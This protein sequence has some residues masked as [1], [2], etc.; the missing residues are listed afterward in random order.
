MKLRYVGHA[1]QIP[2]HRDITK[3]F[4]RAIFAGTGAGKT[5]AGARDAI[6][7]ALDNPG[8]VGY[9]YEPSYMM[10]KRVLIPTL[11]KS[12]LLGKPFQTNPLIESYNQSEFKVTWRNHSVWYFGSLEEPEYS[13]GP[14][15]DYAWI[16][17]ARLVRHIETSL[18]VIKRRLRGSDSSKNYPR[19]LWITT[20][21][22][23]I[24]TR[25][26]RKDPLYEFFEDPLTRDPKSKVYRFSTLDN[27]FLP[28]DYKED[29]LK[30]HQGGLAERFIYGRFANAGSGSFP[31]DASVHVSDADKSLLSSITYGID[32]GWTNPSA[33]IVVGYDNDDREFV[34]DE[35]Y[36]RQCHTEDLIEA[37]KSFEAIYGAGEIFCDPS[38]PE[39]IDKIRLSGLDSKKYEFKRED[40][41]RALGGRFL[42]AGDG[43]P[44][45]YISSKAVNLQAELMEYNEKQKVNDHA[46][47]ALRYATRLQ[48][49][50]LTTAFRFG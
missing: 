46:V 47:D 10:V 35:F 16:D 21:P 26:G 44:R 8:S 17:E 48:P 30:S 28:K 6:I 11:E 34:L 20:T 29:M 4:Y 38:N 7:W 22:P 24:Y 41:I 36:R 27:P 18:S 12:W 3:V 9:I 14:N 1:S 5:I 50:A 25:D 32:F 33:I 42:K 39:T 19:G 23:T 37:L 49:E 13:E 31:F 45:I 15:V 40:G 2:F 43:R